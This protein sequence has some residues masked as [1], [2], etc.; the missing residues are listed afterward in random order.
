MSAITWPMLR[1][2]ARAARMRCA[3]EI[4]CDP[5]AAARKA[6]EMAALRMF[7]PLI[8]GKQPRQLVVIDILAD[9]RAAGRGLALPQARAGEDRRP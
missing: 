1:Y 6:A 4:V 7:A 2:S 8:F 9:R 5:S 3:C